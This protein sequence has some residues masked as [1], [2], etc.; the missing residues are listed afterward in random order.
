MLARMQRAMEDIQMKLL[1]IVSLLLAFVLMLGGFSLAEDGFCP[2]TLFNVTPA[3]TGGR[4]YRQKQ[5]AAAEAAGRPNGRANRPDQQLALPLGSHGDR[6]GC[7]GQGIGPD[8]SGRG[9]PFA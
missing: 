4:E 6:N 2:M 3:K 7:G 5:T 8:L 9:H 1:R